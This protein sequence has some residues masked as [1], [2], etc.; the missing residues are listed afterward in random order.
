LIGSNEMEKEQFSLKKMED[1]SQENLNLQ[2][3]INR[4]S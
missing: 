1:G 3:L 4:F 2:E